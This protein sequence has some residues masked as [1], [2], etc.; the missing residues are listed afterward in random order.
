MDGPTCATCPWW[1]RF[2]EKVEFR[3]SEGPDARQLETRTPND[4]GECR[5]S[6]PRPVRAFPVTDLG[7]WCG[8]HPERRRP[9]DAG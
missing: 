7:D 1:A 3:W 5:E 6:P 8:R 9:G 4:K 2:P